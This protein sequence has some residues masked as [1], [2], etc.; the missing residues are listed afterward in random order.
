MNAVNAEEGMVVI[1]VKMKDW[2][3]LERLNPS[4]EEGDVVQKMTF[5]LRREDLD[6]QGSAGH[7]GGD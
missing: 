5:Q 3:F 4:V 6:S 2:I 1:S 7:D